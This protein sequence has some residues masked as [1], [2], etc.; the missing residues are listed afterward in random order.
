[1]T[2]IYEAAAETLTWTTRGGGGGQKVSCGL[3]MTRATA[4]ASRW[5]NEGGGQKA[6]YDQTMGG[7]QLQNRSEK[8]GVL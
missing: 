2:L 4:A 1:M 7:Q 3:N 6:S 5:K 8:K